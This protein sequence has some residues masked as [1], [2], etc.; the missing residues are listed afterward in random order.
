MKQNKSTNVYEKN[1][2]KNFENKNSFLSHSNY[3]KS[4]SQLLRI[5]DKTVQKIFKIHHNQL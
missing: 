3:A 5:L 4:N 1:V 2:K